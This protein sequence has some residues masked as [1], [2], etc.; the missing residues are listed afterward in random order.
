MSSAFKFKQALWWCTNGLLEAYL[1]QFQQLM[2][3]EP[4]LDESF[5]TWLSEWAEIAFTGP[6]IVLDEV[7]TTPAQVQ[8]FLALLDAATE[9]LLADDLLTEY[10][11]QFLTESFP[12]LREMVQKPI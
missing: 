4:T 10:G 7:L 12:E 5:K 2:A 3:Q 11:R 6:V 1:E 8:Q 9:R